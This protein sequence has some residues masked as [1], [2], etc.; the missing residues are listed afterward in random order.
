M[1]QNH[2]VQ[3][4]NGKKYTATKSQTLGVSNFQKARGM[5][6]LYGGQRYLRMA[7]YQRAN[8]DGSFTYTTTWSTMCGQCGYHYVTETPTRKR[9]F[10]PKSTCDQHHPDFADWEG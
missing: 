8:L 2:I 9:K 3:D 4:L 5:I 6:K 7:T 10:E 1:S